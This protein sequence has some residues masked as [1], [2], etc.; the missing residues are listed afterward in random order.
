MSIGMTCKI[1]FR[2]SQPTRHISQKCC[3]SS[4]GMMANTVIHSSLMP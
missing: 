4:L 3:V 1:F 2:Y